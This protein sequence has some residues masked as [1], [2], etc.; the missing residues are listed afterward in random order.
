MTLRLESGGRIA[1]FFDLDGTLIP[2]PSL[3]WRFFRELRGNGRIPLMNYFRWGTEALRLLP[4]G[5]LAAKHRNKKY[6]SGLNC[7][8]P[9]AYAGAVPFF[10]EAIARVAWHAFSGHEIVLLTGTLQELAQLAVS[11]LECELELQSVYVSIQIYAT[12]LSVRGGQWTGAP[13]GE[14]L[15][16]AAKARLLQKLAKIRRI[17][18]QQS[19]G[20]GDDFEDRYFLDLLGHVNAVNPGS[21]LASLANRKTWTICRWSQQKRASS[22]RNLCCHPGIQSVEKRA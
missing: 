21:E 11:A 10:D 3:E 15:Y 4:Q 13:E 20:Y 5:V 22:G 17:H 8:V 16:G 6:L 12:R 1:A 7:D 9:Q 19:Y 14:V 2:K 18:L